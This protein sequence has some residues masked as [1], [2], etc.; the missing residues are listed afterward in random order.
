MPEAKGKG[1]LL[2]LE[3]KEIGI[4]SVEDELDYIKR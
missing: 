3:W 1:L 4:C 2:S